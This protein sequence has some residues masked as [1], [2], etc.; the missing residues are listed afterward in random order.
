M[1][2]EAALELDIGGQIVKLSNPDKIFFSTRGETKLD[3]VK[4]YIS[5]ADGA[6]LGV[7]ERPTV[8]KR[9]P[10]GAEG[11]P[12]FQKRVPPSAPE[13]IERVEITFP[14]GR[15]AEELCPTHISHIIWAVNLGCLDLNPWPVRRIDVDHPDELRIDLDPQPGLSF[16]DVRQ[17]ALCVNDVLQEHELI[18]FPKTSGSRGIQQFRS[19]AM[20]VAADQHHAAAGIA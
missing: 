4:Y 5:V 10:H 6:L 17:T 8:M 2:P 18:G 14:S 20:E 7:R 15:T 13:W 19:R 11:E 3:L 1:S 9:Y 16:D 12:F